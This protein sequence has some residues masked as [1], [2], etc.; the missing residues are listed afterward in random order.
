M[1]GMQNMIADRVSA[2]E[3]VRLA[4]FFKEVINWPGFKHAG[5]TADYWNWKYL[6]RPYSNSI[7][8]AMWLN[9]EVLSHASLVTSQLLVENNIITA[10]QMGDLYTHPDYR[11]KGLAEHLLSS[12]ENQAILDD[13]K[14]IFAFPSEIGCMIISKRGYKELPIKF[15]QYRFITDP[16]VFFKKVNFGSIKGLAYKAMTAARAPGR[17]SIPNMVKEVA[18]IPEDIGN[19]TREF[20]MNFELCHRH[21]YQYLQWRYANPTGGYFKILVA[22]DNGTTVGIIVLRPY[23]AK[24]IHYMEIVDFMSDL[25]R[26]EIIRSLLGES[27]ALAKKEGISEIQTWIPSDHPFVSSLIQAGFIS[28]P[29][30][31]GERGFRM[32][33]HSRHDHDIVSK[34]LENDSLKAHIMLGDTDWI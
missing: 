4:S 24:G 22:T 17:K 27:I 33:C 31:A 19:M 32:F 29:L 20:E 23:I 10:G 26:P 12:V 1:I 15:S 14:L 16:S 30:S 8:Y 34:L 13:I 6:H 7:G 2:D 3:G 21:D 5:S 18:D 11:G 25:N 28:R 9:E